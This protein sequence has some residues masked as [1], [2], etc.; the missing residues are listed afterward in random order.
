M[1]VAGETDKLSEFAERVARA[2]AADQGE[3]YAEHKSEYDS[4]GRVA[5]SALVTELQYRVTSDEAKQVGDVVEQ[6]LI[7]AYA[8]GVEWNEENPLDREYRFKAAGD[9][10]DKALNDPTSTLRAALTFLAASPSPPASGVRVKAWSD[11]FVGLQNWRDEDNE[12]AITLTRDDIISL[13]EDYRSAL[14][15]HS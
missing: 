14:G 6:W 8:R 7:A 13:I 3:A 10:A 11:S 9:F 15:E 1:T 12:D 4:Y 2:I 5:V